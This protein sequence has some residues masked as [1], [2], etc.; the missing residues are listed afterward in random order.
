MQDELGQRGLSSLGRCE[1]HVA[2]NVNAV[3][4]VLCQLAGLPDCSDDIEPPVDYAGG[5]AQI[6]KCTRDLFGPKPPHRGMHIMV[7]MPSTAAERLPLV[8]RPCRPA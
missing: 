4:S 7:T 6:D 1:S 2:A 3:L 5:R 8:P